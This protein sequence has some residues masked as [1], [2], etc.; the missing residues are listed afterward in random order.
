MS[1]GPTLLNPFDR[2]FITY[3]LEFLDNG[4]TIDLISIGMVSGDGRKMY[5]VNR[6]MSQRSILENKWMRNNVWPHLPRIDLPEM[7]HDWGVPKPIKSCLC[8]PV[9]DSRNEYTCRHMNGR[10]DMDHPD[11]RPLGQIRR[12][13]SDF[14]QASHPADKDMDR[15]NV[16]MW[17]YYGAYD[18]VRL[19][20]LW[21]PMINLP[22]HVPMLTHDLKS[23]AMRLGDPKMPKQAGVEH[24]AL[25]DAEHNL[26]KARFLWELATGKNKEK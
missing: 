14:I 25:A 24:D 6:E 22:A 11:V 13:V 4:E 12:M 20:Q 26:I 21:G 23:E 9:E 5:A 18:H 19:A 7:R 2:S 10:L 16:K 3:D 17:A 15:D 1:A 8:K